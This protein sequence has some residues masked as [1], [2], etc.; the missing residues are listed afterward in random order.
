M[1]TLGREVV[2]SAAF[3]EESRGGHFRSDFP[4][5]DPALDGMHTRVI[6]DGGTLCRSYGDLESAIAT[7]IGT[8][9]CASRR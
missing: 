8:S 6:R 9:G 2:A 5:R 4:Q 1:I 3:R 7:P